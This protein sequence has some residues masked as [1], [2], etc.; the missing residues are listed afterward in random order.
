MSNDTTTTAAVEQ[1]PDPCGMPQAPNPPCP[2]TTVPDQNTPTTVVTIPCQDQHCG[3]PGF[4]PTTT[5]TAT[6]AE[7]VG[8]ASGELPVV[9]GDVAY[10]VGAALAFVA[11]G[12]V[13]ARA[14]RREHRG[15]GR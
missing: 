4:T 15:L 9:G 3:D 14:A 2:T 8:G 5:T 12:A 13:I 6:V 1:H 7:T 11:V 10:L